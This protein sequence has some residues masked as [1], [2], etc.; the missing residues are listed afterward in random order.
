MRSSTFSSTG[1]RRRSRRTVPVPHVPTALTHQARLVNTPAFGGQ[2]ALTAIA[3][4][5][6][7]FGYR[8]GFLGQDV[9]ARGWYCRSPGPKIE[10]HGV[11][12]AD[13]RTAR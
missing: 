11:V 10:L 13:G 3:Q 6:R 8:A 5:S 12:A 4:S 2:R 7:P 9:V 1:Q